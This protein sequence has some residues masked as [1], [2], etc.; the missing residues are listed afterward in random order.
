M[1]GSYPKIELDPK[2]QEFKDQIVDMFSEIKLPQCY[3]WQA[4]FLSALIDRLVR[5]IST[6][7]ENFLDA[8]HIRGAYSTGKTNMSILAMIFLMWWAEI[9]IPG[10]KVKGVV[11]AGT[12]RQV[13]QVFWEDLKYIYNNSNL[14]N[15]FKLSES[16]FRSK[17]NPSISVTKRVVNSSDDQVLAGIHG[18]LSLVFIE[19]G[20][21]LSDSVY[22]T[23][24]KFF[25]DGQKGYIF[26]NSNPVRRSSYTYKIDTTPE[27]DYWNKYVIPRSAIL[28]TGDDTFRHLPAYTLE[29]DE[30]TSRI[31]KEHGEGSDQ[32]LVAIE[33]EYGTSEMDCFIPEFILQ[34]ALERP[35]NQITGIPFI[36]IDVSTGESADYSVVVVR[37]DNA[38]ASI[39]RE[40][41]RY[42]TFQTEVVP[43]IIRYWLRRMRGDYSDLWL[44]V[45]VDEVGVG[46]GLSEYL[47]YE[48]RHYPVRIIPVNGGNT[49]RNKLRFGNKKTEL[50]WW[51][52]EWLNFHGTIPKNIPHLET[53][54]LDIRSLKAGANSRGLY[55]LEPKKNLE[56]STD[57]FDALSYTFSGGNWI[58]HN[59]LSIRQQ[60]KMYTHNKEFGVSWNSLLKPKQGKLL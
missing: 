20:S 30:F 43:E 18:D 53:L 5:N 51:V 41:V 7:K 57:I 22:H 16:E 36:G 47:K 4:D 48:F 12:E 52:R 42:I 19:E 26:V 10:G 9:A 45:G 1:F 60:S 27:L 28:N 32:Y 13:H 38:I 29:E 21:V 58:P 25:S 44:E 14:S 39:Y 56:K 17:K 37:T 15:F 46:F 54:L 2:E 23:V 35:C 24:Q 55:T 6:G 40:K 31:I 50:G 8:N 3:K 59:D 33:G 11:I 49:A 34:T